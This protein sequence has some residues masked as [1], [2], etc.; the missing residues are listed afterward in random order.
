MAKLITTDI[1]SLDG[2]VNDENGKFGWSE[3]VEEVHAS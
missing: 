1:V 2:F 3:P